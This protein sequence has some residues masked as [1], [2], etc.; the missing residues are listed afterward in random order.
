MC[1]NQFP[2]PLGGLQRVG[3]PPE[4]PTDSVLTV[5]NSVESSV[6]WLQ[7][8]TNSIIPLTPSFSLA[9]YGGLCQPVLWKVP[10]VI[11]VLIV[12]TPRMIFIPSTNHTPVICY[13]RHGP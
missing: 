2:F 13:R 11:A 4:L 6:D 10:E 8:S 3:S 9:Y 1:E 7:I 5:C 12:I